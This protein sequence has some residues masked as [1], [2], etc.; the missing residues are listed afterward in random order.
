MGKEKGE[1]K[2]NGLLFKEKNVWHSFSLLLLKKGEVKEK[3]RKRV[4]HIQNLYSK[5]LFRI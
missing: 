3:K 1:R 2:E 5:F 4:L